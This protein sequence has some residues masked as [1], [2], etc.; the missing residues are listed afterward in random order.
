MVLEKAWIRWK[1]QTV[2]SKVDKTLG[3]MRTVDWIAD[4]YAIGCSVY[5]VIEAVRVLPSIEV[6]GPRPSAWRSQENPAQAT[7]DRFS[8]ENNE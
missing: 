4:M 8:I 7:V 2:G 3:K 1:L 6:R 5:H